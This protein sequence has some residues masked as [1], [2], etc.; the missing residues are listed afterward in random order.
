MQGQA[1]QTG[2][3]E[4]QREGAVTTWEETGGLFVCSRLSS[5]E[6]IGDE[7]PRMENGEPGSAP[8][9]APSRNRRK[10]RDGETH[11]QT[12]RIP[13]DAARWEMGA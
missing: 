7:L 10:M 8:F 5:P 13:A 9:I 4:A 11:D 3:A 12:H 2:A 6:G 1:E